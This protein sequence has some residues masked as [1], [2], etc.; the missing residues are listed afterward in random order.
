[1]V[2]VN[3]KWLKHFNQVLFAIPIHHFFCP[4]LGVEI[5]LLNYIYA[6]CYINYRSHTFHFSFLCPEEVKN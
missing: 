6:A 1:M 4:D 3:K 2:L 5:G